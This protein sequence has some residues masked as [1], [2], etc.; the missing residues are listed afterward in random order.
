MADSADFP[1][2]EHCVVDAANRSE[3]D[4]VAR[5]P[6]I[7]SPHSRL[8]TH[9]KLMSSAE[10][11]LTALLLEDVPEGPKRGETVH[12]QQAIRA[13]GKLVLAH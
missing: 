5:S 8:Q 9:L 10:V 4:K 7:E 13:A 6:F 12:L 11:S 2:L 1:S 3:D